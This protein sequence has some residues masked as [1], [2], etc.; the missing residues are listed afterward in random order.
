MNAREHIIE[1]CFT[2][3]HHELSILK[4]AGYERLVK[5]LMLNGQKKLGEKCRVMVTRDVD[6]KIAEELGISIT[7]KVESAGGVVLISSDG[8]VTLDHTFDGILKRE[9]DKIRIK[10]GKLLFS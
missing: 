10:V 8:K 2:K 7:G 3:A 5:K 9:K 1:E 6:R 4:G